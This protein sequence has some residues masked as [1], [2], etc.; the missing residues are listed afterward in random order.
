[1]EAKQ[2]PKQTGSKV[3]S[4]AEATLPRRT[5]QTGSKVER[6]RNP[7]PTPL[8]LKILLQP[9][10]TRRRPPTPTERRRDEERHHRGTPKHCSKPS[11]S[12]SPP[13]TWPP[14]SG[15]TIRR[16]KPWLRTAADARRRDHDADARAWIAKRPGISEAELARLLVH[17]DDGRERAQAAI[18][19]GEAEQAARAADRAETDRARASGK[20]PDLTGVLKRPDDA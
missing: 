14:L 15:A 19:A 8:L 5:K 3:A 4:Q 20:R 11:G 16:P 18:A 17:G 13:T 2:T 12:D 1:V 7:T 9:P 6:F 10:A